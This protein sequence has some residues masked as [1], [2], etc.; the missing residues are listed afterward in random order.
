VYL[1]D[2]RPLCLPEQMTRSRRPD[3]WSRDL[4]G[5]RASERAL[6][7][8]L[9]NHPRVESL[10]DHTDAFDL[11]D[12]SFTFG[13]ERVFV[14]IKEK[15][16]PYSSGINGLWPNVDS[17]NLFILDETVYR[18]IVWQGGG[19]YLVVRD[20][21][22]KRWALFGPWE[23]TL[24]PRLRYQRWGQRGNSGF[25]KGKILLNLSTAALV[26]EGFS[27]DDLLRVIEDSRARVQSVEAVATTE[28]QVPIVGR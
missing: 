16:Q 28:Q 2:L 27:V 24:G 13:R 17:S 7:D 9:S 3:D 14:D 11:L 6:A 5:A 4:E 19:G 8:A 25:L 26:T 21:P 23:L 10:T 20:H 12:F 15:R 1:L 22:G 18:R